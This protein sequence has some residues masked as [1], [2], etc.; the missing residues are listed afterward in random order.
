MSKRL[1]FDFT[2]NGIDP[3]CAEG[4]TWGPELPGG[5]RSLILFS[6]NNFGQA[7]KTAFHLLA[8]DNAR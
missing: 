8:V 2:A 6:D 1:L 4:M 5:G 3:Q 7:G